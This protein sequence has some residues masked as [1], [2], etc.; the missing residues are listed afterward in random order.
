MD[1]CSI[2]FRLLQRILECCLLI[3]LI[4]TVNEAKI[5]WRSR[6]SQRL[7]LRAITMWKAKWSVPVSLSSSYHPPSTHPTLRPSGDKAYRLVNSK[8]AANWDSI[9]VT[10]VQLEHLVSPTAGIKFMP[11]LWL[12]FTFHLSSRGSQNPK[13]ESLQKILDRSSLDLT[14]E[15]KMNP[16]E[17][18]KGLGFHVFQ[19]WVSIWFFLDSDKKAAPKTH[20]QR[21]NLKELGGSSEFTFNK[22][23]Q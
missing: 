3:M 13:E 2:I 17:S 20:F 19:I 6:D 18:G 22:L 7:Y 16:Y 14:E 12:Y 4:P 5:S 21:H 1:L 23:L 11:S 9:R 8:E 15:R 10:R